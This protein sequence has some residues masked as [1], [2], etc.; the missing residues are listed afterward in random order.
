MAGSVP[1]RLGAMSPSSQLLFS[2]AAQRS[3]QPGPMLA[4][5][6]AMLSFLLPSP[7]SPSPSLFLY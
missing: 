2:A 1:L 3:S 5:Q 7:H 6:V 4:A